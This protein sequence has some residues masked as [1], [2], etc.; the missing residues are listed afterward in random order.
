MILNISCL[1]LEGVVKD[2]K[3]LSIGNE[4]AEGFIC[5]I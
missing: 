1:L 4:N 5:L 2:V 3:I